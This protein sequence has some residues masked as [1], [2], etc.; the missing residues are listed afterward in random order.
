MSFANQIL[1]PKKTTSS[2]GRH[3]RDKSEMATLKKK[4]DYQTYQITPQTHLLDNP[5]VHCIVSSIFS[6]S[7]KKKKKE[8]PK[9]K[10]KVRMII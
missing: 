8:R 6:Q 10:K 4:S 3:N 1:A 5:T 9:K 2:S 7:K